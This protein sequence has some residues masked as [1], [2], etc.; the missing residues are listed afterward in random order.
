MSDWKAGLAIIPGH[1]H[2]GVERY[3]EFGIPPG[4]FL[5]AVLCNDLKG[6]VGRADSVNKMFLEKWVEY[7]TWY[8]PYQSQGSP[9]IVAKWMAHR[10]MSGFNPKPVEPPRLDIVELLEDGDF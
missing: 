10:G 4:G 9:E 7:V 2:G 1:M 8:L 5:E 3:V 6:A